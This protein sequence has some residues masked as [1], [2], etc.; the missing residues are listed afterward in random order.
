MYCGTRR[1][2]T[3]RVRLS[4]AEPEEGAFIS[5]RFANGQLVWAALPGEDG[6]TLATVTDVPEHFS[7]PIYTVDT[8]A[9]G[10]RKVYE[11]AIRRRNDPP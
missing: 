3:G 7:N 9:Y 1:L 6:W 4:S 8:T 2:A 10:P 5:P 11:N